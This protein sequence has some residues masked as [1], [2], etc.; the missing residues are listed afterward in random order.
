[1]LQ[2]LAILVCL[3]P[4]QDAVGTPYDL[5]WTDAQANIGVPD[6]TL[7]LIHI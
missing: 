7:S 1:M 4:A 2:T 6:P 5:N 3:A